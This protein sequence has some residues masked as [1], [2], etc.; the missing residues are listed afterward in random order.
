H[1]RRA[2]LM[3]ADGLALELDRVQEANGRLRQL[4][5]RLADRQDP[6]END[7]QLQRWLL[8][9]GLAHSELLALSDR[10]ERAEKVRSLVTVKILGDTSNDW[11][12]FYPAAAA[13]ALFALGFLRLSFSASKACA[14]CG[15]PV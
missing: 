4:D 2:A 1:T 15:R 7:F 5:P 13:L 8:S 14:K 12:P 10:G 6:P 11:A 3:P 9:P